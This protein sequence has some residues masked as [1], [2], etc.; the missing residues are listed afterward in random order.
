MTTLL[1]Q[2]VSAIPLSNLVG[3]SMGIL[4]K[5]ETTANTEDQQYPAVQE[6]GSMLFIARVVQVIKGE[7]TDVLVYK[8]RKYLAVK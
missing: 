1:C 3:S 2:T 6:E 7:A 4:P 8:D 5:Q